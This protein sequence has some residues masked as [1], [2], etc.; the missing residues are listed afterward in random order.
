MEIKSKRAVEFPI[1]WIFIL[2]A[3][4]LIL[5]FFFGVVQKQ[6]TVSEQKLTIKLSQQM[7]AVF[8]GAIESKGTAQLLAVPKPG[9]SFSCTQTCDCNWIIGDKSN[10]F[11]DNL[12]FSPPLLKNADALAWALE[13]KMPFRITNFLYLTNPNIKYYVVYDKTLQDSLQMLNNVKELVPEGV[14]YEVLDSPSSVTRLKPQGFAHTRFA[15][16][17]V[18]PLPRLGLSKEWEKESVSGVKLTANNQA[19][20]YDKIPDELS[21]DSA[22]ST[23]AKNPGLF[24]ALFSADHKMFVCGMKSAFG[25]LANIASVHEKRAQQLQQAM[26]E[27]GRP[28]CVYTTSTKL[29]E[30]I[31]DA[32]RKLEQSTNLADAQQQLS[33]ILESQ[34]ELQKQNENLLR[35]SCPELY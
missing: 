13:W 35:Q 28:E 34:S 2:I 1:N 27:K 11:L 10:P 20:F 31:S 23:W 16:L 32:A 24:A 5:A 19:V 9:I 33:T 4:G 6:K 12:I 25:K 29:F 17:N 15:F 7:E 18:E 26:D 3:G 30:K 22:P 21:F 8:A 14:D